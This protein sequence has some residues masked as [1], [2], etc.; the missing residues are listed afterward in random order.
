MVPVS[1]G[2]SS[3]GAT[4]FVWVTD[5]ATPNVSRVVATASNN[6]ATATVDT[7]T[8]KNIISIPKVGAVFV[9]PSVA[10]DLKGNS[11]TID[12]R[13]YNTN[14]TLSGGAPVPGIA[15]AVGSPAGTNKVALL[16]QVP[17]KVYDQVIGAGLNPSLGENSSFDLS[18]IFSTFK[19]A[20]TQSLAAG[21]YSSPSLGD[22]AA[23]DYR[24]TYVNGDVQFGGNGIGAGILV[25]D[26][27]VTITGQF[28]FD[29][30]VLVKGDVRLSGGG[31]KTH[32][33]GSM[34]VEQ[35]IT[36]VDTGSDLSVSG[37]ADIRFSSATLDT[38]SS[39]LPST[40]SILYYD[41]K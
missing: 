4:L 21:T 2:P 18:S 35:S 14:G 9:D 34:M 22:S 26:G 20:A 38:V 3:F 32:I 1:T 25:V 7:Y 5:T 8:R 39:K 15:T 10:L 6:D 41:D 37:S 30:L 17:V 23:D 13:D 16:A 33:Y 19:A 11:F 28:D 29:G 40:Y 12:G 31:S 36:A 27:S 24:I